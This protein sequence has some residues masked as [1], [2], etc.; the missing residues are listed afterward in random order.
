MKRPTTPPV[1]SLCFAAA[2]VLRELHARRWWWTPE[3]AAELRATEAAA[4]DL[5]AVG[6]LALGVAA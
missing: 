5:D 1:A 2:R 4:R 6:L 3:L